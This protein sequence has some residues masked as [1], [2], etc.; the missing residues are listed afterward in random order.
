MLEV[1]D[2]IVLL[3]KSLKIEFIKEYIDGLYL[4]EKRELENWKLY[5][6]V[7]NLD[8]YLENRSTYEEHSGYKYIFS[9]L[10]KYKCLTD[11]IKVSNLDDEDIKELYIYSKQKRNE[12]GLEDALFNVDTN[13][14]NEKFVDKDMIKILNKKFNNQMNV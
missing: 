2:L 10:D 14:I 13:F 1:K 6:N 9:L 11:I 7:L 12:L 8:F 5:R 3:P 4:I